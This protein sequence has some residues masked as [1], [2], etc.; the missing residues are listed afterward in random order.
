MS[1]KIE[2]MLGIQIKV[3]LLKARCFFIIYIYSKCAALPVAN[4]LVFFTIDF[5]H[6]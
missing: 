3:F 1:F 2:Y 6:E 4:K 5:I